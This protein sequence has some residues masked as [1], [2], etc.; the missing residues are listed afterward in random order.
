MELGER[1]CDAV[2]AVIEFT[3]LGDRVNAGGGS[4]CAVT[5]RARCGRVLF[6]ECG[7]LLCEKTFLLKS[8]VWFE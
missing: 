8:D 5:A 2:W 3:Y 1:S 7:T 6:I 4:D